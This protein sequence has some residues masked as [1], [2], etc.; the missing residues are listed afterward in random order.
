M[1]LKQLKIFFKDHTFSEDTIKLNKAETIN[2][3]K[4]FVETHIKILESQSGKQGFRPY[5]DRLLKYYN[6]IKNNNDRR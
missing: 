6:L 3:Q 2:D 4:K 1:N 5:Y